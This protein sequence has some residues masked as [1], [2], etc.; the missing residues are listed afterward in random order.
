MF[1]PLILYTL[2]IQ[3]SIYLY[4]DKYHRIY[5]YDIIDCANKFFNQINPD[6]NEEKLD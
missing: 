5:L 6:P 4:L 1:L 2:F 3:L